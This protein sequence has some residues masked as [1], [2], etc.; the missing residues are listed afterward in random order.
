MKKGI[1]KW[2]IPGVAALLAGW[3]YGWIPSAIRISRETR[4]ANNQHGIYRNLSDTS[5]WM[6][7]WPGKDYSLNGNRYSLDAVT[8]NALVVGIRHSLFRIPS[9]VI[10]V[11]D[12]TRQTRI[13]WSAVIPAGWNPVS[14]VRHY[15]AAQSLATDIEGLLQSMQQWY[16]DTTHL[17]DLAIRRERVDDSLLVFIHDSARVFPSTQKV[18]SMAEELRLYIQQQ[19]AV[20]T[21]SPM[22][23]VYTTDSSWFLTR[24]A[25]PTS[26]RLPGNTRIRFKWMLGGGNILEADV[27][28]DQSAAQRAMLSVENY[29]QDHNLQAPAIPYYSLVTHRLA[30]KDSSKWKTRICYPVMYYND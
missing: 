14:R 24:V 17:Y 28:G 20:V 26:K 8:S 25:L 7:W 23:N 18:Y 1:L 30:E 15:F 9:S 13:Q 22:L 12:S 3:I 21:D 2:W 4:I 29:M 19:G 6:Q 11:S 16:A 5:R 27:T 10:L